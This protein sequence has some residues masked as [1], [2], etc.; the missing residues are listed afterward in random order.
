MLIAS[1]KNSY[2]SIKSNFISF[3]FGFVIMPL[4]LAV[5]MPKFQGGMVS[6]EIEVKP[7]SIGIIDEDNSN[8]SSV[9]KN[10][11]ENEESKKY[12]IE[13]NE[14]D[15][16]IK[17]PNG[18][19]KNII[20]NHKIDFV[21]ESN[22]AKPSM[23]SLELTKGYLESI[24]NILLKNESNAKIMSNIEDPVTIAKTM[25]E[26]N[27]IQSGIEFKNETLVPETN[28][29]NIVQSTLTMMQYIFISYLMSAVMS[30]KKLLETTGVFTRIG[31]LPVDRFKM[32]LAEVITSGL[33]I[34][35]FTLI[36]I[37]IS[38]LMHLGFTEELLKYILVAFIISISVATFTQFMG[39]IKKEIGMVIVY[40]I[41]YGQIVLGGM[42]GP[43]N[44]IFEGT[45]IERIS[46]LNLNA[47]L[48]NP[49]MDIANNIFSISS[50]II[51]I[52]VAIVSF[53]LLYIK[54]KMDRVYK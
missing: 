42:I 11:F 1:L 24:G 45:F 44:K 38:R 12:F 23:Y 4:L 6:G 26:L 41:L 18:F 21:V 43:V 32:E 3:A 29:N 25:E 30:G 10:I 34:F 27:Y 46:F 2:N 20:D 7:I 48:V 5:L 9:V 15:Y 35:F 37:I 13:N 47:L 14:N 31:T 17:I 52:I 19:E 54:I 33:T 51:P 16:I 22:T 50:L 36:Y 40:V 49:F 39:N 28:M 53:G 8:Y